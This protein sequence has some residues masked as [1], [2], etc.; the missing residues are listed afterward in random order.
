MYDVSELAIREA[1]DISHVGATTQERIQ[2][3]IQEMKA[4]Q[5]KWKRRK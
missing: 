2:Q 5:S 3:I 1:D 4:Q